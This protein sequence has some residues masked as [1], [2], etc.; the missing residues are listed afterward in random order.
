M[1]ASI[2]RLQLDDLRADVRDYLV[3]TK[4][5][6]LGY[7]GEFFQCTAHNPDVLLTFMAFTEALG[8]ALPKN[9]VE[10]TSLSVAGVMDNAYERHQHERLCEKLGFSREWISQVE[11][12]QPEMAELLSD[13]E[14]AV[15]SYVLAAVTVRGIGV[16]REFDAVTAHLTEAETMAVVMLTG[17]YVCHAM[18]VNTLGLEPPVASIFDE[19]E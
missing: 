16:E 11:R 2:S 3:D 15:Q 8:K 4:V 14:R 12:L 17:R 1:A 5:E 13:A 9:L 10:I 19:G 18:V 7:L 6:R